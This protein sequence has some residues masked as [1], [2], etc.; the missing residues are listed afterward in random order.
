MTDSALRLHS[1]AGDPK[2][3]EADIPAP[4][5]QNHAANLM[6]L[7]EGDLGCVWFGGTQEGIAD[8]SIYFSRLARDAAAW[9]TPVK[10]SDDPTRSEQNPI[11][12]PAPDGKLWLIYTAQRSGNQDTAIVRYRISE[13]NGISWG[14]IGTLF[15]KAGTF[16][17]Q[18]V[19]V[20]DNGDW[21][22][23]VF[24]CRTNPGDKWVGNND[25]S[26]VMISNDQGAH[27]REVEVPDSVG[28]VHMNIE[29]MDDGSLLALFRSRWADHVYSSRSIDNGRSWS[30]PQ[31]TE[32]PNNNSSIQYT[33]LANG[34]LAIVYNDISSAEATERRVSL[35]DEI[36]DEGDAPGAPQVAPAAASE[37]R[38]AF[39]GTPR[40]PMTLA[41]SADGGKTW[42]HKRNLEVG[43]GYCMSNNSEKK[44]NREFSYPSIK[45]T[46]DGFIH[47]AYTYWRQK[48]KYV[49]VTEDW[50]N[51]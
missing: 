47:I 16:V 48:I 37:G 30:A 49:R 34:H 17:R 32:L 7:A 25:I 3:V 24:Y 12:F 35:Y 6:P 20:L 11:L 33:R 44:V 21:L 45:Q 1:P 42:P 22:I 27:W 43:D 28:C 29:K 9:S 50:V 46:P 38:T 31:P 39:W 40:A 36:E 19:V 8:I 2:R 23:P 5:I 51:G 26:A 10:L 41:I 14:P 4:C 13:D 15:E 18:P